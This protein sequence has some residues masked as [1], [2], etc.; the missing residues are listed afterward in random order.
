MST[1]NN[2]NLSKDRHHTQQKA[3]LRRLAGIWRTD[4]IGGRNYID[5]VSV[6]VGARPPSRC[7]FE[8]PPERERKQKGVGG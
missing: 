8:S 1:I 7:F 3:S 6:I 5:N 4:Q 2:N